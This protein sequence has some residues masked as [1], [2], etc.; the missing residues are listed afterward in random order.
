MPL[1]RS[2]SRPPSIELSLCLSQNSVLVGRR[3]TKWWY[4]YVF[5]ELLGS[6]G[7]MANCR[8]IE[9]LENDDVGI[10]MEAMASGCP[11]V[12]CLALGTS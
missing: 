12:R 8:A 4:Y 3:K 11:G 10:M 7:S 1:S 9:D 5:E 6:S 2:R